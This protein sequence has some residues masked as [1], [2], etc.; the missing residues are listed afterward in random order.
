MAAP[1]LRI[2]PLTGLRVVLAPARA[3][4]PFSFESAVTHEDA[5]AECPLCEGHESWTPPETYA[6]RPG[7][8]APD[9]PGWEVRAVPN[10][11]P[12]LEPGQPGLAGDPLASG[13]GDP[14]LLVAG[15]ATGHHE[16]IGI[17]RPDAI[18]LVLKGAHVGGITNV[19][20]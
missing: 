20:V 17:A 13:R 4:R 8:G 11:Y 3:D 6:V 14:E 5:R 18:Q 1:E 2:D 10:K 7:G 19:R 16:V 15:R 9:T 12:L